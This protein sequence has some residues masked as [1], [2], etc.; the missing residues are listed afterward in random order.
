MKAESSLQLYVYASGRWELHAAFKEGEREDAIAEAKQLLETGRIASVRVLLE[1]YDPKTNTTSD[2]TVFFSSRKNDKSAPSLTKDTADVGRGSGV[3]RRQA[4]GPYVGGGGA[5]AGTFKPSKTR[6]TQ[7]DGVSKEGI[8]KKLIAAVAIAIVAGLAV[9]FLV[10]LSTPAG[11]GLF[12]SLTFLSFTLAFIFAAIAAAWVL[13]DQRELN[14]I[15]MSEREVRAKPAAA[16]RQG[17]TTGRRSSRVW[18]D[19]SDLSDIA[20]DAELLAKRA[21]QKSEQEAKSE[22]LLA[23]ISR[24]LDAED[25]VDKKKADPLAALL[26]DEPARPDKAK[27]RK[28]KA[29]KPDKKPADPEPDLLEDIVG[30]DDDDGDKA[31]DESAEIVKTAS[32][33]IV[34]FMG[35]SLS[36][37][38]KHSNHAQEKG[39]DQYNMFGVNLYLAGAATGYME[40]ERLP[41]KLLQ[42]VIERANALFTGDAQRARRFVRAY[43]EYVNDP[44]NMGM[45]AKGQE[46]MAK[47]RN[48]SDESN[49]QSLVWA[50]D[51]WNQKREQN[52]MEVGMM[53]TDIVGSTAFTQQHGDEESHKMVSAHNAIVR[54]ALRK[55]HGS[56]VK[57]MGDG[58]MACFRDP[59]KAVP[60]AIV[61][62][63]GV[64]YYNSTAKHPFKIRISI[65]VGEAVEEKGDF[66]GAAVQLSARINA[67]TDGDQILVSES[68]KAAT[69]GGALFAPYGKH[70]F[71]GFPEKIAIF[72]VPWREDGRL[73]KKAMEMAKSGGA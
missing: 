66:F 17:A 21:R 64:D 9:A 29:R 5:A 71:K 56:E 33:D 63:R 54:E 73:S 46:A 20:G 37:A 7:S 22:A 15:T 38:A 45:Y 16:R 68:T 2:R 3:V 12:G 13:L 35:A 31:K 49:G 59:S 39:F 52:V 8:A 11:S 48:L 69:K 1:T 58:I 24:E 30:S 62:M 72:E 6:R 55:F 41:R 4:R 19:E 67:M 40:K 32:Q 53:F 61:M 28:D 60:S 65:N 25:R 18:E 44:K 57:H 14:A 26:D 42:Q 50:L 51:D 47:A 36:Y 70:S 34:K 43:A 27:D 10:H 23:E